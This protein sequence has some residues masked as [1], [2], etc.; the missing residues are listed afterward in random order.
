MR[1][2]ERWINTNIIV[3]SPNSWP[4]NWNAYGYTLTKP[5]A[6]MSWRLTRAIALGETAGN[7]R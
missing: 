6:P 3:A 2:G 1:D 4:R 7:K 5:L